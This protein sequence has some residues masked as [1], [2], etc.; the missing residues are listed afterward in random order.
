[1]L[2]VTLAPCQH[3]PIYTHPYTWTAPGTNVELILEQIINVTKEC[4]NNK[5][6]VLQSTLHRHDVLKANANYPSLDSS[7]IVM[8]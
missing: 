1:M 6:S 2:I 7:Q 3:T 5:T 8:F 4:T